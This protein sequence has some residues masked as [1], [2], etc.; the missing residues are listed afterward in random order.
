[1]HA[2]TVPVDWIETVTARSGVLYFPL[3]LSKKATISARS[4]WGMVSA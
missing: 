1:M 4:A 3:K 2:V